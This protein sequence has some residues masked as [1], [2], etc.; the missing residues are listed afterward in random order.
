MNTEGFIKEIANVLGRALVL[1][2]N[3]NVG[4]IV[5]SPQVKANLANICNSAQA[6]VQEINAYTA[7]K[8]DKKAEG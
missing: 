4:D 5:V 1:Q 6:I 8:S 7:P 2:L 3:A